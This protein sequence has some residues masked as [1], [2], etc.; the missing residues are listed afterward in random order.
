MTEIK[1]FN[2]KL[3]ALLTILIFFALWFGKKVPQPK[4][5][6]LAVNFF[7]AERFWDGVKK[8]K[9]ANPEPKVYAAL[10]PHHLLSGELISGVFEKLKAQGVRKIILIGPN[11]Y[12]KGAANLQQN[13]ANWQTPFGVVYGRLL[14][15][16]LLKATAED[17]TKEHSVAGLMPYVAYYLPKAEVFSVIV[18]HN[19]KD[20]ELEGL[21]D[22]LLKSW[23]KQTVLLASVDFSHY[24]PYE[25][26]QGRDELTKQFL[27]ELE[28]KPLY[29]LNND[30]MDSPAS[31]ALML[32]VCKKLSANNFS[33]VGHSNSAII[34]NNLSLQS[35]TS[36]FTGYCG[37]R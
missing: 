6:T 21:A 19:T 32:K 27:L 17:I 3:A 37:E 36:Y 1:T 8:N 14:P 31:V 10:V 5:D 15:T 18:K 25:V 28:E 16:A 23:D 2:F 7:E 34:L 4:K 9:P 20:N 29:T 26:A 33:I 12:E 13:S 30:Y 22:A 11:H 24:L 35:T